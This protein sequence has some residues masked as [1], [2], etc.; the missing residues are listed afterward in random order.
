M[1]DPITDYYACIDVCC[2]TQDEDFLEQEIGGVSSTLAAGSLAPAL[3]GAVNMAFRATSTAV[4]LAEAAPASVALPPPPG[5]D[6]AVP[7]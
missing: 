4:P 5:G 3:S 2:C 6:A 1:D 7:R